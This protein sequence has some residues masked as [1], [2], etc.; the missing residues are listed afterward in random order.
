MQHEQE[1]KDA[2]CFSPAKSPQ[3][4]RYASTKDGGEG[5]GRGRKHVGGGV[6]S[7]VALSM[8]HQWS[9]LSRPQSWRISSPLSSPGTYRIPCVLLTSDVDKRMINLGF[10]MYSLRFR[11][12]QCV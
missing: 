5:T 8:R 11:H 7:I 6:T 4:Q 2:L 1:I 12:A 10:Q 9:L 3:E